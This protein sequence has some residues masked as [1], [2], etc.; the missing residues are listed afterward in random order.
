MKKNEQQ[1]MLVEQL[2]ESVR[3]K[4][5]DRRLSWIGDCDTR[6]NRQRIQGGSRGE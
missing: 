2:N 6:R 3:D 1:V 5:S 4:G